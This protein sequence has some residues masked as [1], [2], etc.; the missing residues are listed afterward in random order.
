MFSHARRVLSEAIAD[1]QIP[2]AVWLVARGGRVLA[3]EAQGFADPEAGVP[4]T[5]ETVFD[6]ASLTKVTATLPVVL[7]LMEQGHF[8]LDDPLSLLLPEFPTPDVKIWHLLTHTGGFPPGEKLWD[9]GWSREQALDF[10]ARLAPAANPVGTKVVYSDISFQLLGILV[11]RLTG[12]RLDGACRDM[13]FAPL[14]MSGATFTPGP[15]TA[16]TE[17]R[18]YLGR[19]QQGQ[20]HDENATALAGVAG[21]AGL[22]GTVTDLFRYAAMWMGWEGPRVLA[23]ATREAATRSWFESDGERRGLGWMLKAAHFASCGDLFSPASFGHTGFTGTSIWMDPVRDVAVVLLTNRVYY[24]RQDH[25]IRLRPR[26][27]NAVVA[28]LD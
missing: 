9:R 15:D 23:P 21:H 14:G 10:L 6:L 20:V 22:F 27:H 16:P 4:M 18:E 19:R 26:F 13:V 7:K 2:G 25:I 8:R 12:Q 1:R 28:D 24:G 5:P 11:E 17:Y 3:V